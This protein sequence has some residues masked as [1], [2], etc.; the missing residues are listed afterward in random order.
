VPLRTIA[1]T[2]L[3]AVRACADEPCVSDSRRETAG[4]TVCLVTRYVRE[5]AGDDG[6]ARLH[7]LAGLD[8]PVT[9]LEDERRWYSYE[10]KIALFEAAAKVLGDP[11]VTRHIGE[12]ALR[13]QVGAGVRVLLRTLGSPRIVLSNV[14]KAC[15]KFSTVATMQTL[16]LGRNHAV[17]TYELVEG[18]DPH[19]LDCLLNV[20]L[21]SVIGPLFGMPLLDVEH[22]ECQVL[23]AP[24]C[25]YR[26][27]WQRAPRLRRRRAV[28]DLAQHVEA[29]A[30][31]LA[32]LQSTSADLVWA[33]D[34]SEVLERIVARAN[35]AVSAPRHLLAV[36]R[37]GGIEVHTVGFDGAT[38]QRLAADLLEHGTAGDKCLVRAIESSRRD[39]GVLAA[40][41]EDHEFFAQEGALLA[42]YARNAAAALDVAEALEQA[43]ERSETTA[44]L[45]GLASALAE[46]ASP[47]EVAQK[48][49]EA[50]APVIGAD[51]TVVYL[52]DI[53]RN[54]LVPR[55]LHGW[56]AQTEEFLLTLPIERRVDGFMAEAFHA[57][58]PS[59]LRPDAGSSSVRAL[60]AAL[61]LGAVVAVPIRRRDTLLGFACAGYEPANVPADLERRV[62]ICRAIADHAVVALDNARL[63]ERIRQRAL[64][65]ELTGVATRAHFEEAAQQALDR[66][67]RDETPVSLVFVDLDGFKEVNDE[68]GHQVGDAVLREIGKRIQRTARS[69]DLVGRIGG[70]EFALLLWATGP[71]DA[72]VFAERLRQMIERPMVVGPTVSVSGSFGVATVSSRAERYA[73]LLRRADAAMYLAKRE[74][75]NS[76]RVAAAERA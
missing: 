73:D 30:A 9:A 68:R 50:M 21:I 70:D 38:A 42:A 64:Y 51:A 7:A 48:V 61:G 24:R 16:E 43:R 6:V 34:V 2:Q 69:G 26:V 45:L 53:E 27:R 76:C 22:G 60:M 20:G 71:D 17:V 36:R 66:A 75:R 67:L 58:S 72:L 29:L 25:V 74:G 12:D 14:A 40:F 18:K 28:R 62:E 11:D 3:R 19:R 10:A 49:A 59:V 15:P 65:D 31:Q 54:R 23:G 55:G 63:L 5:R 4:T 44:A 37:N 33:D 35:V 39:Y 1:Q 41:Y 47:A 56:S 57:T 46:L 52:T 32:A 8:V 13:H